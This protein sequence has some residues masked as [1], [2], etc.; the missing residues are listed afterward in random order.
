MR[1]LFLLVGLVLVWLPTRAFWCCAG[2]EAQWLSALDNERAWRAARKA[3][4][5]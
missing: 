1:A 5:Q 3:A 4:K 2:L